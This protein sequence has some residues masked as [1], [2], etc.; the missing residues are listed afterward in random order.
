MSASRHVLLG[1][2]GVV[3][4]ETARA[5]RAR[6]HDPVTVGRRPVTEGDGSSVVA[7][8]LDGDDVRRALRGADV[9]YLVAGLPY[10][11]R[12]WRE[13]WPTVVRHAARAA[14]DEGVHLVHLDNVYAYG[15]VDGPMTEETPLRPTSRKGAVR[16]EA[17]GQL[18]ALRSRGL[19]VTTARSADFYGPG[20]A[21]SAFQGFVVDR[22]VAGKRPTWLLDADK[23][24]SLTYTPDVGDALAVLGTDERAR[25]RTWHV[26]TAPPLTG[27]EWGELAGVAP[28]RMSV[29]SLATLRLGALFAPAARETLELTYQST[30]P[31]VFDSSRASR[32]LGLTAT[33]ASVGVAATLEHA[34]AVAR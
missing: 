34:R 17:L 14:L 8:L 16:A 20:A 12:M 29:M 27:R 6:G 2:H 23:P 32:E 25:G 4:R 24:H 28:D 5:L 3:G 21:T 7:D 31:Y 9:A 13:Q 11:T 19:T 26:P 33:P 18:D 10:S 22:V 1:G 30:A 15:P